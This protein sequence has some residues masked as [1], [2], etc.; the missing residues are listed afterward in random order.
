MADNLDE[1]IELIRDIVDDFPYL[2]MDTEFPGVVVR[3]L[4][5]FKSSAE[6]HYQTLRINVDM[7]KMIQLGLTFTDNDGVLPT[8]E[9]DEYCVWQFNF[10]EFQL[11]EDIYSQES[12]DLLKQSGINFQS[13]AEKGIEYGRFGELLMSSGVVLNESM[14]WVTFHSGYDFGYLLKLL[15]CRPLPTSETDFFNM[16]HIYFPYRSTTSSTS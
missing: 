5:S 2:A 16:L 11:P 6:Y 7:L 8:F 3:P 9:G 1:E 14:N 12:I 4:G 10:R 15:T 13:F